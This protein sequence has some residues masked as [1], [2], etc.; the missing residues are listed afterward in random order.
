MK[1]CWFLATAVVALLVL[2]NCG[3]VEADIEDENGG[4]DSYSP[5]DPEKDTY[6]PPPVSEDTTQLPPPPSLVDNDDDGVLSSKDCNDNNALVHPYATETCNGKDDNCDNVIDEGCASPPSPSPT[7]D[8]DK[9]GYADGPQ[10][11]APNNANVHPG[12]VE[13]CNSIDD[14]CDGVID[15]QCGVTPTPTPTP[16]PS[17]TAIATFTVSYPDNAPRT[18]NVQVY[19]DKSDLGGWWDKS[20]SSTSTSVVLSLDAVPDGVCGFRINV[21]ENNPATSWLCTGN[22]STASLDPDAGITVVYKGQTYTKGSFMTWS[23]PGGTASGCSALLKISTAAN[24][25]P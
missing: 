7:T 9:D 12:A 16:T 19:D 22:G 1:K 10:D 20:A 21:S 14:D 23:A 5:P 6:A 18:L 8:T 15:E 3:G 24:C 4:T 17:T 25:S 13:L 2:A 11:C